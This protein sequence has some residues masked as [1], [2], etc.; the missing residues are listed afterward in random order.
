MSTIVIFNDD[1]STG[2]D[3]GYDI[4][5]LSSGRNVEIYTALVK[6]NG[7]EFARQALPLAGYENN[8]IP[9]GVDAPNGGTVT[10]SA[11]M[12]PIENG[13]FWLE[14]RTA[15][16]ITDLG[17]ENYTVA[18]P[19]NTLGTGRFFIHASPLTS[20]ER[21]I[22]RNDL[23]V[24]IWTS[25]QKVYIEGEVSAKAKASV[26]D[27][28][29]RKIYESRLQ[30]ERYNTFELPSVVKGVYMVRVDDGARTTTR[31]VVF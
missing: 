22:L 11:Y 7:F 21:V 30:D 9:V 27:M 10:F 29:G 19:K 12:V 16:L 18:L 3:P 17:R 6:D 15:G 14:D 2:L 8:I 23:T 5:L 25:N 20:T 13:T 26:Y 1:M 4:G 28:L 31:K 24:R